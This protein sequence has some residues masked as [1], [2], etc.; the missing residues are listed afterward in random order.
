M[1]FAKYGTP[2]IYKVIRYGKDNDSMLSKACKM[3]PCLS[4]EYAQ[5]ITNSL[6]YTAAAYGV[7]SLSAPQIGFPY[8]LFVVNKS[9]KVWKLPSVQFKSNNDL[10]KHAHEES[11]KYDVFANSKLEKNTKV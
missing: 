6:L 5:Y 2:V 4:T 10:M 7:I 9:M 8:K 3:L 11:K 1:C